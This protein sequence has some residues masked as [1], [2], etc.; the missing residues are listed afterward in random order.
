VRL[1]RIEGLPPALKPVQ[2]SAMLAARV[3]G[4]VMVGTGSMTAAEADLDPRQQRHLS[5]APQEPMGDAERAEAR[6]LFVQADRL[7]KPGDP[8]LVAFWCGRLRVLPFKPETE[9]W[10][11]NA[12]EAICLAC[13]E[14]PGAVWTNETLAEALRTFRRWPAP[15]EVFALLEP[16]ARPFWIS[17][18]GLRRALEAP[19]PP[20]V[21]REPPSEQALE[22]V[23]DVVAKLKAEIRSNSRAVR[24]LP[25]ER[26]PV[27]VSAGVLL[28]TYERLAAQ[29]DQAAAIR[30]GMLRKQLGEGAG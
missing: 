27:P 15:A 22:A 13:A 29:G 1:T 3:A 17:R 14:L 11:V 24:D 18:D 8:K 28:A 7:C 5:H 23:A 20:V 26:P 6:R 4:D 10:S 9:Q 12:I 30:V 21:P 19:K 2:L 16:V 25:K